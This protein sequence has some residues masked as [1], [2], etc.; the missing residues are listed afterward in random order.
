MLLPMS[1][2]H[3]ERSAQSCG[4]VRSQVFTQ[5]NSPDKAQ[6]CQVEG[7]SAFGE[8]GNSHLRGNSQLVTEDG[9]AAVSSQVVPLTT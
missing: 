7:S 1:L 3:R 5:L 4:V 6:R 8:L 9:K 2:Q